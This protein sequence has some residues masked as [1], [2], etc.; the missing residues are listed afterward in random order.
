M[1]KEE[2]NNAYAL[3]LRV[4]RLVDSD[5]ERAE[6]LYWR[7]L[8]LEGMDE[9]EAAANDWETLLALPAEAVPAAMRLEAEQRLAAIQTPTPSRTPTVTRTPTRTPVPSATPKT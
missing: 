1:L 2:P 8:S 7:A 5:R 4:E 6:Y 3:L 9:L